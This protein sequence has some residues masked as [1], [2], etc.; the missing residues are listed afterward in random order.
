MKLSPL[1]LITGS[2]VCR[3][4]PVFMFPDDEFDVVMAYVHFLYEGYFVVTENTTVEKVLNFMNRI[5][6]ILPPGSFEVINSYFILI[7]ALMIYYG[8]M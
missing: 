6:L 2:D 7:L 4:D 5:G 3:E 8:N 1:L